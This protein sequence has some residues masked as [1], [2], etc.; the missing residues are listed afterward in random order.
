MQWS[1]WSSDVCSSDLVTIIFPNG[2]ESLSGAATNISWNSRDLDG[3]ALTYFVLFSPDRGVTWKT[4]TAD[5]PATSLEVPLDALGQTRLGLIRVQA[6]DGFNTGEDV[7]D[8]TFITPNIPPEVQILSPFNGDIFEGVQLVVFQASSS[9][10][11]D[12]VLADSRLR[13]TSNIDGLLGSGTTLEIEVS[14][15]A[16]RNHTITLAGTDSSG[17]MTVVRVNISIY[18]V[19]PIQNLPMVP[20]TKSPTKASS[21]A[22]TIFP[23]KDSTK[24]PTKTPSEA[25]T[26]T[27]VAECRIGLLNFFLCFIRDLLKRLINIIF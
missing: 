7:S 10:A 4:L 3:D 12:G 5:H 22:P 23:I 25:P 24:T 18:R 6:S 14:E 13:W 11:E 15:L 20:P 26:T 16:E 19:A 9:D 17:A 8:A 27:P 21:K 1:D 2:G